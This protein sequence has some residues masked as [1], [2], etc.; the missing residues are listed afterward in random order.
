MSFPNKL[1]QLWAARLAS[2]IAL[3]SAMTYDLY[4]LSKARGKDGSIKLTLKDDKRRQWVARNRKRERTVE[5]VFI[6]S[7]VEASVC[8]HHSTVRPL[9][10]LANRRPQFRRE[11]RP[12]RLSYDGFRHFS[13]CTA[14][15]QNE[16]TQ[17][18]LPYQFDISKE[19]YKDLVNTYGPGLDVSEH[20]GNP[21]RPPLAPRLVIPPEKEDQPPFAM[22]TILPPE[23]EDH[24]RQLKIFRRMLDKNFGYISHSKFWATY[25]G[26]RSP[27][28][29]YISDDDVRRVFQHLTWVQHKNN[30]GAMPRYMA[31][32]EECIGE[33]VPV[34]IQEWNTAISFAGMWVR[35][36]SV[37][38]VKGAVETWMR[39]ENSGFRA[40]H[41]TFNILFDIAIRANRF[42]LADTI[43]KELELRKLPQDQYFRTTLIYYAGIRGDGEAVRQ[44]FRD[45]VNAGELIDTSTMNCVILSLIRAGE[46]SAAEHVFAK[47][48][49]LHEQKL[50]AGSVG[51][52]Q[53]RRELMRE[54]VENARLLREER[55]IH[56]GSFFGSP[57]SLD[58]RRDEM[59]KKVPIAPDAWTYRIL[60]QHHV[61]TSANLDR[62]RELLAEMEERSLEMGASV[63]IHLL[64]GFWRHGGYSDSTWTRAR[65]EALWEYWKAAEALASVRAVEEANKDG[66]EYVEDGGPP[67]F[68]RRFALNALKAFYRCAGKAKMLQVWEEIRAMW[69]GM[70]MD[71]KLSVQRLVDQLIEW[72]NMYIVES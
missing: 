34:T 20:A 48:K 42:A 1:L 33:E 31:F 39:M 54:R 24:A 21:A 18:G 46:P 23:D 63:Y 27:R 60:I 70:D 13:T 56:E 38:E 69:K 59:Q 2:K 4:Q 11:S 6:E 28:L 32:L 35:R 41:I 61:Y 10:I 9:G 14:R 55:R 53:K 44:A 26:L 66:Y 43:H 17:L 40:N 25:K 72:D 58:Q 52:W 22:R 8:R 12:S 7:L 15:W 29:R 36:T 64:C 19:E 65:L 37:R 3:C 51:Q 5:D 57:F 50:G 68:S 49:R 45:L 67:S 47:M 71:D 62:I 30:E 16:A